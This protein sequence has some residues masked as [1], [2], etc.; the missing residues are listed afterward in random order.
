MLE[1][2]E[3]NILKNKKANLENSIVE[4]EERKNTLGLEVH[5]LHEEAKVLK[6][7]K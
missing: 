6:K 2:A 5:D 7:D 1:K 4:L 3:I